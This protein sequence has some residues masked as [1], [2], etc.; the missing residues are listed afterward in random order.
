MEGL[1]DVSCFLSSVW[2][3]L[4]SLPRAA[5]SRVASRVVIMRVAPKVVAVEVALEMTNVSRIVALGGS[6]CRLLRG[7]E[8][9]RGPT[10]SG[11]KG[12]GGSA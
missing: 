11:V 2:V 6:I 12:P 3:W 7:L 8:A 10:S 4:T 9:P 1:D 5:S